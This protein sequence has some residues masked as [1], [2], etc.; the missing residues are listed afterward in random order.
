MG[1]VAA[2]SGD[3]VKFPKSNR[4]MTTHVTTVTNPYVSK[5]RLIDGLGFVWMDESSDA[6]L[7]FTELG[8]LIRFL[9]ELHAFASVWNEAGRDA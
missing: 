1:L 4:N 9:E 3:V 2:V 6:A 5:A 8:E 7:R